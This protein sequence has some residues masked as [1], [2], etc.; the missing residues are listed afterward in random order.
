MQF[1]SPQKIFFPREPTSKLVP[2]TYRCGFPDQ[3]LESHSRNGFKMK[4]SVWLISRRIH[5]L[6]IAF[7]GFILSFN[8]SAADHMVH[9]S[10]FTFDPAALIIKAGDTVTWMN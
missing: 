3:G 10:N 8:A 7:G 1:G 9:I 4:N 5:L 2:H 6:I